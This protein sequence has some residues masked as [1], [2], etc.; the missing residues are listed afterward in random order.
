MRILLSCCLFLASF[1]VFSSNVQTVDIAA[2]SKQFVLVL[3]ANPTTGYQWTVKQYDKTRLLLTSSNYRAPDSMRMGAGGQ[4]AFTFSR[5]KNTPFPKTTR[6]VFRY[7]RS[8]EPASGTI[9]QVDLC[10]K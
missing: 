8:W 7:A 10:F 9:K 1:L 2:T 6:I 5:V 3:P 4:M